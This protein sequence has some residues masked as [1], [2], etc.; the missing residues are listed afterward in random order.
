MAKRSAASYG[1]LPGMTAMSSEHTNITTEAER[2]LRKIFKRCLK[3]PPTTPTCPVCPQGE[4]CSL[5]PHDCYTCAHM[6]CIKNPSP[7]P[8]SNGPNVGAIAGGVVGG[9][10]FVVIIVFCV[11]WFWIRRR[12]AEQDQELEEEWANDE[13]ASQKRAHQ[14][15]LMQDA[16]STRTRGSLANSIL[17]R[18]SN[19]IQI[20]YIPGVTNRNGSNTNSIHAPVP[21]V[22]AAHRS[23]PPKSPLSNEGDALFF[24]PGDLRDSFRSGSS[25][26]ASGNRSTRYSN[27]RDTRYTMQSITPSLARDSVAS[28]VFFDDATA[29]PMPTAV[30]QAA[31]PRM[32]SL[33]S[34]S[35]SESDSSKSPE[36]SVASGDKSKGLQ[37]MMPGQGASP[38]NSLKSISGSQRGKANLVTVGGSKGKGRFPV[39]GVSDAS[40]TPSRHANA[41]IIS[42]PLAEQD[43]ES[44]DSESD[45][46]HARARK[47]LLANMTPPVTQPKE[48][49]FFDATDAPAAIAAASSTKR[50][51]PYA[52][53]ASS[54]NTSPEGK[55]GH[56]S[57]G[58]LS[59]VLEEATKRASFT[60]SQAEVARELRNST[61]SPFSDEHATT[62]EED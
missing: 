61:D 6:T 7:A 24:R 28:D 55:R 62:T 59:A 10:A 4:I 47:S 38:D 43:D 45:E 60:P 16:A 34:Y 5:V 39:R 2:A 3:C 21:P 50:P 49:P 11:Y 14:S 36:P 57:V 44:S 23:Q 26:I 58:G 54:I 8:A 20:A 37:V 52:T 18:A 41:P 30:S 42:S 31:A 53:M 29:A 12:R 46:P 40:S 27:N 9:V 51:N 17:S 32:V 48:S 15:S 56:K 22:P 35:G 13:I 33:K 19:I 1:T 25:S